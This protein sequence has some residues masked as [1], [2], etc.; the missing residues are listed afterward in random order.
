MNLREKF[1]TENLYPFQDGVL[2]LVNASGAPFYLT[3]GTAL[4]RGYYHH[5]FSDDLDVFVNGDA[6]Y[7]AHVE[8]VFHAF[9]T[10]Q[11]QRLFSIDYAKL[12]RYEHLT[13][14][15]L[16]REIDGER[17]ELKV[18]MVNDVAAHYGE[19]IEHP[20]FGKL[21]H[22]RN[23]LSNKL[24]A[25]ARYEAKD[26]ADIWAIATRERFDWRQMLAEAKT[27]DAGVEPLTIFE[28]LNSLPEEAFSTIKWRIPIEF[29]HFAND[30][31]QIAD[32]IFQQRENSLNR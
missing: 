1:Y 18:D 22:W 28:I 13:Q 31:R 26:I 20:H 9:E 27:K 10:A 17:V 19:F 30:I 21:D 24:S 12:R 25:V 32:D 29:A 5:R 16:I 6:A 3:G 23:M 2:K 11:R 15:F 4:S 8:A 14:C 7:G